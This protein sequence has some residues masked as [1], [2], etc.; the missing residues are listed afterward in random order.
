MVSFRSVAWLFGVLCVG[1]FARKL[2]FFYYLHLAFPPSLDDVDSVKRGKKNV[3]NLCIPF[4]C[5][6]KKFF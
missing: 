4:E 3:D 5:D 2:R 6:K 1:D